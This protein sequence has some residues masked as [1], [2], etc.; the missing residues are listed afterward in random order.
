MDHKEKEPTTT[1]SSTLY[2]LQTH[3]HKGHSP[4][5]A[6][7]LF[8][9]FSFAARILFV[10]RQV[11]AADCTWLLPRRNFSQIKWMDPFLGSVGRLLL[12]T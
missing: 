10:E 4:F 9:S 8:L 2:S 5:E 3:V 12:S 7:F 1:S 11:M 6:A